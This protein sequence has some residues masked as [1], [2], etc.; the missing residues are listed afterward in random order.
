MDM[1]GMPPLY[2]TVNERYRALVAAGFHEALVWAWVAG[3]VYTGPGG[4]G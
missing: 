2:G 1:K 3:G 4:Q